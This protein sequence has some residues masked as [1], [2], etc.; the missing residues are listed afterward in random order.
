MVASRD[1][2]VKSYPP[3]FYLPPPLS[4]KC[5]LA[6][7]S[8]VIF[9]R[10]SVLFSGCIF[11]RIGSNQHWQNCNRSSYRRVEP[12]HWGKTTSREPECGGSH[13]VICSPQEEK[14]S[15][16]CPGY[17]GGRDHKQEKLLETSKVSGRK[18]HPDRTYTDVDVDTGH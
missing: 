9:L 15:A 12:C 10:L 16:R 14:P 18:G 17:F 1:K 6:I 13:S 8:N 4:K 11:H 5:H 7:Y 3:S 2:L